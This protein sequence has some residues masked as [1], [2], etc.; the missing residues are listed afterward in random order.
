MFNSFDAYLHSHGILIIIVVF[1]LPLFAYLF[2]V[3]LYEKY[4]SNI[5]LSRTINFVK[6]HVLI[7]I[8]LYFFAANTFVTIFSEVFV[9]HVKQDINAEGFFSALDETGYIFFWV[10]LPVVSISW[11][12]DK[13]I[14][15]VGQ[16]SY[17]LGGYSD[18]ATGERNI[19]LRYGAF[20][21]LVDAATDPKQV[22]NQIGK[23][24]A[25]KV[26]NFTL[27]GNIK[28]FC[29]KWTEIDEKA[30]WCT[31]V[32]YCDDSKLLTIYNSVVSSHPTNN[33]KI[34][35][36]IEGYV[37]GVLESIDGNI[38]SIEPYNPPGPGMNKTLCMFKVNY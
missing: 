21:K 9:Q 18:P 6:T 36:F 4:S 14:K 24:F 28:L 37:L 22:G 25:E 19:S 35:E 5:F 7:V 34:F 3:Q 29:E 13:F 2:L 23:E 16:Y 1:I 31:K 38:Q 12:V 8:L 11:L 30:S 32:E 15:R 26:K 33:T 27:P 10:L 17:Y 20:F